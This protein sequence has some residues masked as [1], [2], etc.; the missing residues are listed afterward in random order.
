MLVSCCDLDLFLMQL[1]REFLKVQE[2]RAGLY[3]AL[4]R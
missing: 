2:Q 4:H 3:S 1:L